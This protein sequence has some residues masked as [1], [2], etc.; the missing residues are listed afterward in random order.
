MVLNKLSAEG[1]HRRRILAASLAALA[2][3]G[4]V[5][6]AAGLARSTGP[7]DTISQP[8]EIGVISDIA[9]Q[10]DY[11]DSLAAVNL[12]K[13]VG[14][15][16]LKETVQTTTAEHGFADMR[17]DDQ[18]RINN[19]L[20]AAENAGLPVTLYLWPQAWIRGYQAPTYKTQQSDMCKIGAQIVA[21]H[22]DAVDA[23]AVSFE[24]NNPSSG[25]KQ[26]DSKSPNAKDVAAAPYV[27]LLAKCYDLIKAVKPSIKIIGGELAPSGNDDPTSRRPSIS[28]VRFIHDMYEAFKASGRP[29]PIMDLFSEHWYP[30]AHPSAT[31]ISMGDSK[32]LE[33]AL[34]VFDNT[35]KVR[36]ASYGERAECQRIYRPRKGTIMIKNYSSLV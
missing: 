23:V 2:L 27:S 5:E 24:P 11:S 6:P 26:F 10:M 12:I 25:W 35:P 7:A 13:G 32:K 15:N 21:A 8:K 3:T 16:V 20:K 31:T 18:Q 22:P 1:F 33:D 36:P 4:G 14:F 34:S 30:A 9:E 28:P 29:R 17:P 19:S